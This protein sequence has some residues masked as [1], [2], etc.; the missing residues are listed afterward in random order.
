M[1]YHIC[2]HINNS[3]LVQGISRRSKNDKS[4][5]GFVKNVDHLKCVQLQ[6]DEVSGIE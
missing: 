4:S 5:T 2:I 6:N 1:R 3:V